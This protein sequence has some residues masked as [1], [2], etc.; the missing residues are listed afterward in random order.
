M[1]VFNQVY[2]SVW[3]G[4]FGGSISEWEI[5]EGGSGFLKFVLSKFFSIIPRV[6]D[7]KIVLF[8]KRG[9]QIFKIIILFL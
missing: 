5:Y 2:L 7:C 8:V 4:F 3:L 9:I 6:C 1:L